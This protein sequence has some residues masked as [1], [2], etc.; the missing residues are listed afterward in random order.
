[1]AK[2]GVTFL[3]KGVWKEQQIISEQWVGESATTFPGN[4]NTGINIPG[5]DSGRV[6]YSYTWWTK[7]YSESG[8]EIHIFYAGGWGGQLIMVLPEVNTVVVFTGGNYLTKRPDFKI[9][10]KY[11]IPAI[12]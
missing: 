10:E 7:Q 11:V 5:E 4:S 3:N 1:M 2:I 9:F 8:K 12:D 6:G